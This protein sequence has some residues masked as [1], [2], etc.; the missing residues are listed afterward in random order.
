MISPALTTWPPNRFTPSRCAEESRPLR[1]LE[2]PFLCAMLWSPLSLVC[3]S[4]DSSSLDP[5]DLQDRQLL[6]VTLTLVV[7]G[8]VLELVDTDLGTLGVL[9]HLT[10]H[11]NLGQR[12]G[13]GGHGGAVDD[14]GDRQRHLRAG[15]G[16][17]LLDLDDVPDRDFVLLAA[18][19]DDCVGRHDYVYLFFF[20]SFRRRALPKVRGL[21]LGVPAKTRSAGLTTTGPGYVTSG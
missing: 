12:G 17:E 14:Q 4:P 21:V 20:G 7:A 18:G 8:L 19:L 1:E 15:L 10:G 16:V 2:A 9:E 5:S 6:T 13:V 11:R 3:S